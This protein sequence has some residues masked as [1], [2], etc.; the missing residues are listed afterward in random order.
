MG[1]PPSTNHGSGLGCQDWTPGNANVKLPN[2][3]SP[4]S[5]LSI[6]FFVNWPP[7]PKKVSGALPKYKFLDLANS[8]NSFPWS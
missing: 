6:I 2:L 7:P 3:I 5:P 1:P 4:T 8:I